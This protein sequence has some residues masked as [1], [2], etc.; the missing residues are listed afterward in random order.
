MPFCQCQR[1]DNEKASA[2]VNLV[3]EQLSQLINEII[4]T[5]TYQTNISVGMV[6]T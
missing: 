3:D 1:C 5:R 4:E 2:T 6:F